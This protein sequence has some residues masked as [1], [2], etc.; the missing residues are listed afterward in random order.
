VLLDVRSRN[1]SWRFYA[2]VSGPEREGES[3]DF[4]LNFVASRRDGTLF[5][6]K[7]QILYHNAS[8]TDGG[9]PRF[10]RSAF[11]KPTLKQ[12]ISPD[13]PFDVLRFW[14]RHLE[15]DRNAGPARSFLRVGGG[16]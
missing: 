8:L 14:S 15:R 7:L 4:P 10:T 1:L 6:G 12:A 9:L 13:K 16:L 5:L 11:R 2:N 3:Y